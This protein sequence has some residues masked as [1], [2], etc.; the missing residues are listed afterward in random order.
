MADKLKTEQE[1]KRRCP[2][3]GAE[4]RAGA[5]FCPKC[6]VPLMQEKTPAVADSQQKKGKK[7]RIKPIWLAVGAVAVILAVVVGAVYV[8]N[9][10]SGDA[11][12][13]GSASPMEERI[14]IDADALFDCE[15]GIWRQWESDISMEY[16]GDLAWYEGSTEIEYY[17]DE[18]IEVFQIN[19]TEENKED[20]CSETELE[21][22]PIDLYEYFEV[23]L[24]GINYDGNHF[25]RK[26]RIYRDRDSDGGA[27]YWQNTTDEFVYYFESDDFHSVE[28]GTGYSEVD[29]LDVFVNADILVWGDSANDIWMEYDDG[30]TI[31]TQNGLETFQPQ[32]IYLSER[33]DEMDENEPEE[34][35]ADLS[36]L[37]FDRYL[38]QLV[39]TDDVPEDISLY[40]L[41]G[42]SNQVV[43][44]YIPETEQKFCFTSFY[45]TSRE[46][47][48][49]YELPIRKL[50]YREDD[51]MSGSDVAFLQ[52]AL[53]SVGT[54]SGEEFYDREITSVFDEETK[55]GVKQFQEY[56]GLEVDGIVG[57]MTLGTL[58]AMLSMDEE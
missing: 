49:S 50:Y 19:I 21:E 14:Q 44:W 46:S 55:Q 27:F 57:P 37:Q 11:S 53:L 2:M 48:F 23:D 28:T 58:E 26:A 31:H 25:S 32:D 43:Y 39:G 52:A 36:A 5:K 51:L 47:A 20:L 22:Y 45:K 35:Y 24:S 42:G 4:M 7:N 29:F 56:M 18:D 15:S 3:C 30:L 12:A 40:C 41:D 1:S 17:P 10:S 8:K 38:L 16:D 9:N 54:L 6:G 13:E 33:T 34:Y